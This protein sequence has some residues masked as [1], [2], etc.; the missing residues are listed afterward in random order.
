MALSYLQVGAI[1]PGDVGTIAL[2]E[3]RNLLLNVLNFILSLLQVN[4]LDSNYFL[5]AVVDPF[6]HF[7][8]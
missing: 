1:V 4:D 2:A 8:K 5:G 3:H 7:T 6:I